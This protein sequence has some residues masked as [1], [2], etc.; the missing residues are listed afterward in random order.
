M[1]V[2]PQFHQLCSSDFV[3]DDRWLLYFKHSPSVNTTN[4]SAIITF[5][6]GDFRGAAGTSLF[7]LMQTLCETANTTVVNAAT[8]FGA[9]KLVN[10]YP[11]SH[12]LFEEKTTE[13]AQQFQQE[14]QA[15][16][17]ILFSQV[18]TGIRN[19]Q[20]YNPSNPAA[21][22]VIGSTAGLQ[23][24]TITVLSPSQTTFSFLQDQQKLGLSCLCSQT[25]TQQNV[26]L[27]ISSRLHQVCSSDFVAEQWWGF[28][29]GTDSVSN[30]RDLQLLSIQ[31]RVL[32]SLC[33]LA[34]QSIDNDTSAFLNNKLIT[35][36]AIS[37]SSFQ[38]QIDSLTNAFIA[39]TPDKFRRTQLFIYETFR[40]NQLLVVPATDW[41][42]AFTT[43]AYNYVIATV[44]RNSF[45]NNY[46]CIT[47]LDSF[48]RPLY[49]DVNYNKIVLPGVVASCLPVD[50]IRLSTLECFFNSN[51]ILNLT[52]IASTRNT[53]IWIPKLLNASTSSIYP[54]NTS[55]GSLADSLFVED[56][57][58]KSNYSSYF[59]SCA[60]HSCSYQ[61]ID[62]NTI[63]YIITTVLGLYGG[64][65][66]ILRFIVW[67][68]WRMH[69][70]IMGWMQITPHPAST[71]VV[72]FQ[73]TI[74]IE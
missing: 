30:F 44:P 65:T 54:S 48:S 68:G 46:S 53:T 40:A 61:Y 67:R 15:S 7:L 47:S 1:T 45:G 52:S 57:G 38:A 49:I 41:Q 10:V 2:T 29:W 33:T 66:V 59:A 22:P 69:R 63:L 32:A 19:N 36:E 12:A 27:S 6:S 51:C 11:M 37:F 9:T 26:F 55:I 13:L 31:F 56:W 39:Q 64:L 16:F 74:Y 3:R 25:S 21:V 17:L 14:T 50:G 43:A 23:T 4:N 72:P 5:G 73:P 71:Q 24:R 62:H 58:I 35:V 42:L 70:K 18:N 34:Q 8:V 20:F 60:P 28:L